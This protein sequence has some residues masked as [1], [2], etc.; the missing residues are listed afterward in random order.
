MCSIWREI[1]NSIRLTNRE[2]T[3]LQLRDFHKF[4]SLMEV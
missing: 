1:L 4:V 3:M 2:I